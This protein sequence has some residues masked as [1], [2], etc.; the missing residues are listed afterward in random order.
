[1]KNPIRALTYGINNTKKACDM[2]INELDL[3]RRSENVSAGYGEWVG[4]NGNIVI[5]LMN[6]LAYKSPMNGSMIRVD[7]IVEEDLFNYSQR[8]GILIIPNEVDEYVH[9]LCRGIFRYEGDFPD[10]YKNRMEYL[11]QHIFDDSENYERLSNLLNLLFF[12]AS[13]VILLY[14][15]KGLYDN[16]KNEL[17]SYSNY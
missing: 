3:G 2:V 13:D 5:H 12:N 11:Q 17:I 14:S 9:L 7:P 4:I 1:M 8:D 10:Y 6:H 15:K 16:I